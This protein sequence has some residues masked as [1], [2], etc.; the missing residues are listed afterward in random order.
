M[1]HSSQK[2]KPGRGNGQRTRGPNL[3]VLVERPEGVSFKKA[4][5]MVK[6]EGLILPSN[7]RLGRALETNEWKSL[8]MA[9]ACWSGTMAGFVEPDTPFCESKYYKDGAIVYRDNDTGE[10]F[11]FPVPEGRENEQN[12]ILLA[13]HPYFDLVKDGNT[14]V[15]EASNVEGLPNFGRKDGWYHTDGKFDIPAGELLSRSLEKPPGEDARY[16][17]RNPKA[18]VCAVVRQCRRSNT[19]PFMDRHPDYLFGL[20]VDVLFW[21]PSSPRGVIVESP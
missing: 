1:A 21:P 16:L 17:A 19:P 15:V 9:F 4:F 18:G 6:E 12:T 20:R 7:K 13:E 14:R 3:R 8:E 10:F 2:T 11:A 5:G